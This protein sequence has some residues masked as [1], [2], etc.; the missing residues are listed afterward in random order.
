MV[1]CDSVSV[2]YLLTYFTGKTYIEQICVSAAARG[3][4]IGRLLLQW[5]EAQARAA[6]GTSMTLSVLNGNP[7]RRLYERFGFVVVPEGPCE[8]GVGCCVVTCLMGRPYG[9]CDPHCGA[10]EMKMA[11]E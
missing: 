5:A 10:V 1:E 11:L 6:N 8:Q 7:A 4:G 9:V 3:K 2:R